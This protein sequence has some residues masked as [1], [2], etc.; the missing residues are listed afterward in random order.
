MTCQQ[1]SCDQEQE[2]GNKVKAR[3]I[4]YH[5]KGK[6]NDSSKDIPYE[7]S[8]QWFTETEVSKTVMQR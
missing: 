3:H 2:E 1:K 5:P 7:E 4:H 6:T 8:D